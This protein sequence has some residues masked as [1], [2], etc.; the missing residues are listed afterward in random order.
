[1]KNLAALVAP[2]LSSLSFFSD[3]LVLGAVFKLVRQDS[4]GF[5]T[6]SGQ[7]FS[8]DGEGF[9]AAGTNA[10]WLA[11]S[12]IENAGLTVVR[13]WVFNDRTSPQI[14]ECDYGISRFDTI[15][16][17]AEAHG[18][19]LMVALTN[20]WSGYGGMDVYLSQL[21]PGGTHD[22]FYTDETIIAAYKNY[23]D[24]LV[25]LYADNSMIMACDLANE[26][27]CSGSTCSASS[28]C[29]TTG[30]HL[31]ALGD[32]GW[33]E[34]A[35]PPTY[36]SIPGVGVSFTDNPSIETLDFGTFHSCPESWGQ[37]ADETAWGVQWIADHAAAQATANKPVIL[38][39]FGV[40][41]NQVD[42]YTQWWDEVISS[43][44]TGDLIWQAGSQLSTGPSPDDGFAVYP[45]GTVY[46]VME[47]AAATLKARG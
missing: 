47:S 8:L 21:N 19:K 39:E 2:S 6:T 11:L 37:S 22:T 44:L 20:N 15:V 26:T 4:T 1:M 40:T 35:N 28:A 9:I 17:S 32:E 23:I 33:F 34:V 43:G 46:P 16:A 27:R 30:N 5:V 3:S 7:K 38:E 36:H 31:V 24:N 13:T 42:T 14:M 29:D 10:Y 18:L 12:D 25:G 45:T 41:T